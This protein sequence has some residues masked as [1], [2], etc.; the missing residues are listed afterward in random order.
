MKTFT[1]KYILTHFNNLLSL[2]PDLP[3]P[4]ILELGCG[5]GAGLHALRTHYPAAWLCGVDH[6]LT[7]LRTVTRNMPNTAD[8]LIAADVRA[9]PFSTQFGAM[10]IR[11]PDVDRS[12]EAWQRAICAAPDLLSAGGLLLITCYSAPE[13]DRL[14]SW[15]RSLPLVA[16]ALPALSQIAPPDAVGRD[17][18]VLV[19]SRTYK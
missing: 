8:A 13:S 11:H 18:F 4:H 10:V 19:Y 1:Q 2:L 14:R 7:A 16:T 15:L 6:D 17:R 5:D 3:V 9:L 12:P